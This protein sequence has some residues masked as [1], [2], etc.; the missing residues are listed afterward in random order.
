VFLLSLEERGVA[1]LLYA[2]AIHAQSVYFSYDHLSI[3]SFCFKIME[4]MRSG[5][6]AIKI[7]CGYNWLQL[8]LGAASIVAATTGCGYNWV[9][10]Q[11]GAATTG[12]GNNWVRL[13]MNVAVTEWGC[14]WVRL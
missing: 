12:Y 13:Q 14:N 10:Q 6:N 9:R 1:D 7:G 2:L 4:S 5:Y 11:R 8:Q 3:A